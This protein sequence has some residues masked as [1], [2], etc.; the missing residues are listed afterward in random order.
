MSVRRLSFSFVAPA[1]LALIFA[2][3]ASGQ[4]S[5]VTNTT[6][7]PIPGAGHDYLKLLSETVNPGNGSVSLRVQVPTPPG[8]QLSLPF[9]FAYDSNGVQHIADDGSGGPYWTDNWSYPAQSGWSYTIPMLSH[10]RIKEPLLPGHG[11]PAARCVYDDFVVMQDATGGRHSLY[12]AI[13]ETPQQCPYGTPRVPTQVLSGGDDYYKAALTTFTAPLLAADADGTVYTF[14]NWSQLTHSHPTTDSSQAIASVASTIEDRNGNILA[15]TDNGALQGGTYGSLSIKDTLG[16]TMLSTSGFGFNGDTVSVSGLANLYTISWGTTSTNYTINATL[17]PPSFGQCGTSFPSDT[18]TLP[19]ITQITLPNNTSYHFTYDPAYGT[20]NKITYPTGGYVSYTWGLNP[21]S[22]FVNFPGTDGTGTC[23]YHYDT[24]AVL[25][26]YVSFDGV[27]I[28]LQQDF[29]YSTNW[30]SNNTL[31]DTKIASVKTTDLITGAV[32]TTVYTY[33]PVLVPT[34]PNDW[35]QNYSQVPVEQTI[36]YEDAS[37]N[38]LQSVTKSWFDQYELK[39][40]QTT[41]NGLTSETDYTYGPGA[42]VTSRSDYDFAAT[43]PGTL[44]R[45]TV[46]NY[47]TFPA[48]HTFPA[49]ASIFDR[50]CQAI[51]YDGSGN[52]AAE[53]DYLYDGETSVCGTA[54]SSSTTAVSNLP[55]GTHDE[56]NYGPT[57]TSPRGNATKTT[58]LCLPSCSPAVTTYTFDETGQILFQTDP[59]GNATCT[60]MTGTNHTTA[61][62]YTDNYDSPP[63][64]NTNAYLTKITNPLGQFSSFKYAYSDGQLIQSTDLNGLV[65]GYLYADSLRRLTETDRPDG[66]STVTTYNDAPPTPSVT[67]A[68]KINPTKTKTTVAVMDGLGHVTQTQL[69]SDP[70]NTVYADTT[71]NGLGLVYKASNPYRTG[72]DITSS[73]GTTTYVYDALSRKLTETYPDSSVLTTA[74]CGPNTLVTDPANRW[75]RSRS[76]ALGRMV[77]VDEPNAVGATVNSNGCTGSSEPI[78]VTSYSYNALGNLTQVVQNGSHQRNFVYDSFSHLLTSTNPEVQ[79]LTYTYDLN[80]NVQTKKDARNIT[81]TYGYDVLNRELTRTYSNLDPTVTTAY[82]Q[83]ACLGLSACQNIGHRT[84]MTDAAGSESWAYQ[85][86]KPN[87]RSAHADLRTTNSLTKPSTYYLDFAGNVTKAVYPTGR[88]INYTY[89]AA[90]RPI[91]AT[92]GS[93][94]ITY[95]TGFQS[96][97][98]T[99]CLATVTCYTPQGSVYAVSVGQTSTFTGLNVTKSYNSRLQPQE[100]KASSTGGSAIDI[101][102]SFLDPLNNNKN[103]GHVFS[104]TNNLNSA[105]TQSFTYDQVNRITSAG[106]FATTGSYCWGYQ[107]SYDDAWGNLTSQAGWTPNYNGCTQTV[108]AAVTADGNNHI[109]AFS[110]DAAGN[111]TGETGFTYAW[112]AESQLKSAGGVNYAYDG[113]G[114]RVAKVGSKLY[115]YGSASEILAETDAAGNTQNEY[116]FFGGKRVA[117]LPAGSTAQYYVEDS[118]GSSRVITSNTGVG[119]YDADFYPFG[120]ERAVTSTCTQNNYKF[121]GKERDA[122]TSTLPGNANGNDEFGARYY[123]NRFGRWLSADW[124]NV[125]V[126]VPYANLSNPQTLNLY[127]MVADD[128]ES[129]A[130][131]DGH[132]C[133]LEGAEAGAEAFSWLGPA[134]AF[135]GGA[136]GALVGGL[137]GVAAGDYINS[138]PDAYTSGAPSGSE[139]PYLGNGPFANENTSDTNASQSNTNDKQTNTQPSLSDHKQALKE[140]QGKVGKLPKG[141]Q[142]KFGSPQRGDSKKG[143][144]LDPGHPNAVKLDEKG[145]HF[146]YWDYTGGKRNS[147]GTSGAVPIP[148]DKRRDV[149]ILPPKPREE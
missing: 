41:L 14:P 32:S 22:E 11:G 83:P 63:S 55:A 34:V 17:L 13:D 103:A 105:R 80:G 140:V 51:V 135:L 125:P 42:Q 128:P 130:D 118:L 138:H 97:P 82:D 56:T 31:W 109:S 35:S 21:A 98:G 33:S 124:S 74:Y 77:E 19:V 110:Y 113:D 54:A 122:E 48:T 81:T 5:T 53:T 120:G 78:W 61:Y 60:D 134:G 84:S 36:K 129:F 127:A 139:M 146:N 126:A 96:S 2:T 144:R 102:Y 24:L 75:R 73:P 70:Q 112:D 28:A 131:L 44:L 62:S 91:T 111:A 9:S 30:D 46:T 10:Q 67:T 58:V 115:W 23:Y 93:N 68:T 141:K 25:H 121:Q 64:P 8:R 39:T 72:T 4:I 16:R 85:V 94:G 136:A 76:D 52:P 108:M 95:A 116:V 117:L 20:I 47:Q 6:S 92:D 43:P 114:H 7:T 142:G 123:S 57:A 90:N 1:F 66:G 132:C 106:T 26:R 45:K 101:T 38:V 147:G 29:T 149:P 27:H 100:F 107:Y 87:S 40:Q 148:P 104:I 69:T 143:Y 65:T 59:C 18:A 49:A 86:D 12:V 15:I 133:V 88:T 99:G 3:G 89:D 37:S 50:P 71:Y 119:C 79:T 145:K 137:I